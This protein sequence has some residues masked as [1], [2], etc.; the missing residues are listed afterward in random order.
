MEK[1]LVE[2]EEIV[3]RIQHVKSR[4]THIGNYDVQVHDL[5]KAERAVQSQVGQVTEYIATQNKEE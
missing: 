4:I 5:N 2:L 3:L 1:A